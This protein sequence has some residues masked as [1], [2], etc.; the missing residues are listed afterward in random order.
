MDY[1]Q[2]PVEYAISA[3]A[4]LCTEALHRGLPCGFAANMPL[5]NGKESVVLAPGA[6]TGEDEL[7]SA[8]ARLQVKSTG[9]FCDFLE[10]LMSFTGVDF[11]ILS[12]FDSPA[13]QEKLHA[14][15]ERGN[16]VMLHLFTGEE[17]DHA[18]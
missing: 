13:I 10:E 15:R 1:E 14:L 7:L 9:R 12:A 2:G 16:T 3:A 6:C 5:D 17:A 8:L 4:T 11:L 18:Q